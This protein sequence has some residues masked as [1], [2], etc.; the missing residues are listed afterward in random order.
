M[1]LDMELTADR[2]SRDLVRGVCSSGEPQGRRGNV[3]I[4]KVGR[5]HH[6]H[7]TRIHLKCQEAKRFEKFDVVRLNPSRQ[8][9]GT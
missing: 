4:S 8:A 5:I 1:L 3:K 7:S 2:N 6:A 9:D